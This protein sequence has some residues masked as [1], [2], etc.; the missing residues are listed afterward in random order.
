V[1]FEVSDIEL[2]MALYRD[3]FGLELHEADHAGDDRWTNGRHVATSWTEGAFIHFALY[4]TKDGTVTSHA[5][6]AFEVDD[7]DAAHVRATAAGAAVVHQPKPQ[8]W[9]ISA[10]YRDYDRNIIELTQ[11]T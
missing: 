10:R 11:R 1:V 4:A 8:P 5:Q 7:I 3:A 9:G 6:V 2:S